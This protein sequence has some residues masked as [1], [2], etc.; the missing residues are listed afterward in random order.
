MQPY[1]FLPQLKPVLWGGHSLAALKGMPSNDEP[2][3]ESWEISGM[4]GHESVVASG[5]E[6]GITLPQLVARHGE[7]LVGQECFRQYGEHFPLLVK[8]IDAHRP[9]SVQVHPDDILAQQRH[10]CPGKTEMWF[11]VESDPQARILAGVKRPLPLDRLDELAHSGELIEWM[12]SHPSRPGDVF[13][14]PAGSLHSIGAGNLLV[15]IQQASDV[16]YRLYDYG[17]LD[18]NGQPRQLHL[19]QAREAID[20]QPNPNIASHCPISKRGITP[21]ANCKHFSVEHLSI[22]GQIKLDWKPMRSFLIVVCTQGQCTIITD[23]DC[24]TMLAI[25]ESALVPA[26]V[27]NILIK[28]KGQ[29]I[30][31]QMPNNSALSSCENSTQNTIRQ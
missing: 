18:A 12:D 3:G 17:R 24:R 13:F 23:G 14:L 19:E 27:N 25:G 1:K 22:D 2:I 26:C 7:R 15:E 9:L 31:V 10:N 6:A 16:T 29:A 28:G 20:C 4:P 11:I 30:T 21:L 5:P 8:L